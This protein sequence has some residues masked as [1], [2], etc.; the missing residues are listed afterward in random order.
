[1]EKTSEKIENESVI[2]FQTTENLFCSIIV[3]SKRGLWK[4]GCGVVMKS[5]AMFFSFTGIGGAQNFAWIVGLKKNFAWS[6]KTHAIKAQVL[7]KFLFTSFSNDILSLL[8]TFDIINEAIVTLSIS[9]PFSQHSQT[10]FTKVTRSNSCYDWRLEV[11][12]CEV[13]F[14]RIARR[15]IMTANREGFFWKLTCCIRKSTTVSELAGIGCMTW[16]NN[17]CVFAEI[18]L[19][20]LPRERPFELHQS[21]SC[22]FELVEYEEGRRLKFMLNSTFSW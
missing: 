17:I 15:W 5:L 13:R 12:S 22:W 16:M 1:M 6:W 21:S 8:W 3:R 14:T 20:V 2:D 9:P 11:S 19:P 18:D 4:V 7:N 10:H